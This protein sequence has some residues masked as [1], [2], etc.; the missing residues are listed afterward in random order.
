[1]TNFFCRKLLK[2][3]PFFFFRKFKS[4]KTLYIKNV[5]K[6]VIMKKN[7]IENRIENKD[8]EK[9]IYALNYFTKFEI[10][11][12][13][14]MPFTFVSLYLILM[15]NI[16][17]YICDIK[18]VKHFLKILRWLNGKDAYPYE[19]WN[20]KKDTTKR[21]QSIIIAEKKFE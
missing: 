20:N 4:L 21:G 8:K 7:I 14:F 1:M 13:F 18:D 3:K 6:S 12:L 2:R 16:F 19:Y 5:N 11:Y 17:K 9:E 15:W 10:F